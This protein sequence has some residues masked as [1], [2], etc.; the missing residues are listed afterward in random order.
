MDEV[1]FIKP[2]FF[3]I[4]VNKIDHP[5]DGILYNPM[6]SY[7]GSPNSE[8]VT[9]NVTLTS[10]IFESDVDLAIRMALSG[11]IGMASGFKEM[12]LIFDDGKSS[13][14]Y[15]KSISDFLHE[16]SEKSQEWSADLDVSGP[17]VL[18]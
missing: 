4:T 6:V 9:H 18:H 14:T 16:I 8:N 13:S 15:H 12:I 3:F 1:I 5:E 2:Q 17:R 10:N 11:A 7:G